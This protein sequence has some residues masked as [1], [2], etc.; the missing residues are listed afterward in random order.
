MLSKIIKPSIT[1]IIILIIWFVTSHLQIYNAYVLPSPEKVFTTFMQMIASK[2][3]FINIYISL[4]RVLIGFSIAVIFAF[5][6]GTLAYSFPKTYPYYEFLIE[7]L[8]NV[9]P[10]ATIPLLIL[11]FGIGENTKI[12]MIILAAFFPIFLNIQKGF[13][14]ADKQLI[15]VGKTMNLKPF[16]IFK[17]IVLPYAIPDILVGMRI[18]L[19]YSWRAI[20]GAEMIAAA[21]GLGYMI[22]FAQQMSRSDKII[23]GIIVIGIIG[24][25]CDCLFKYIINKT[26]KG[27]FDNVT[28]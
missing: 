5:I 19:G 14:S 16:E 27:R 21:S 23:I 7:F 2:E 11:W 20:I 24:Y 25:L 3:I 6:L 17:R 13:F 10:L 18:G 22:L 9:P 12:I 28:N 15:E 8:R 26:L 4:I 1:I